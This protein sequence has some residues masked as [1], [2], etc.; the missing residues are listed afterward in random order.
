M[1]NEDFKLAKSVVY[2]S[3][4]REVIVT[5][6]DG[7]RHAWPVRLLEMVQSKSDA[8]VPLENVTDQQLADVK[9]YGGGRYILW[10]ELDQSF[11]IADLLAGIY[12]REAWMRGLMAIAE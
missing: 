1:S 10:D 6:N 4:A 3:T 9:L 7:S 2:D 5:L 12:G 11:S 8:W